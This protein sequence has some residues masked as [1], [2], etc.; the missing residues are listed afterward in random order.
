[1]QIKQWATS[2]SD[3]RDQKRESH[4][5]LK[6]GVRKTVITKIKIYMKKIKKIMEKLKETLKP[7]FQA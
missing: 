4:R 5:A 1:M 3:R 2:M 6:D 7:V